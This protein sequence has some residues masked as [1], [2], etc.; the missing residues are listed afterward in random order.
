M[1]LTAVLQVLT[2]CTGHYKT[3]TTKLKFNIS[4]TKCK[5][6]INDKD[7][8]YALSTLTLHLGTR[9]GTFELGPL[10]PLRTAPKK[11]KI[12]KEK[13]DIIKEL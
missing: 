13:G 6:K 4:S 3:K 11:A 7:K 1:L 5:T 2:V 10:H 8:H 12:G 9:G